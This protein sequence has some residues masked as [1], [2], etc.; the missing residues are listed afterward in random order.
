MTSPHPKISAI[1]GVLVALGVAAQ[2]LLDGNP[3]TNPDWSSLATVII[4]AYGLFT[5]RQNNVTSEQATGVV[6]APPKP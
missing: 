3:A 2:S 5:A 1:V 6:S 4:L